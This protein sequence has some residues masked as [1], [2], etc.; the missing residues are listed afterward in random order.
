MTVR[1]NHR[2]LVTQ[3][4]TPEGTTCGGV[5]YHTHQVLV[6]MAKIVPEIRAVFFNG[7]SG[8]CEVENPTNLH[9]GAGGSDKAFSVGFWIRASAE[10][11]LNVLQYGT[12]EVE[13]EI[14]ANKDRQWIV[15]LYQDSSTLIE[16]ATDQK[17]RDIGSWVQIVVTYDGGGKASGL[18]IYRNG[19]ELDATTGEQNGYSAMQ[20]VAAAILKIG[21]RDNVEALGAVGELAVWGRELSAFEVRKIYGVGRPKDLLKADGSFDLVSWWRPQREDY[22]TVQDIAGENNATIVNMDEHAVVKSRR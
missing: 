10:G 5:L 3:H 6:L 7:V 13:W 2:R 11:R 16:A 17:Q 18:K 22:P 1:F 8:Y 20:E 21:R 9:M 14:Y 4:G 19:I 15:R 12:A